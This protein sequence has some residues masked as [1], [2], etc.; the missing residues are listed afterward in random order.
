VETYLT[1]TAAAGFLSRSAE[2]QGGKPGRAAFPASLP[3]AI[4]RCQKIVFQCSAP[5]VIGV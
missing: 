1:W 5:V 2:A 3:P 4:G